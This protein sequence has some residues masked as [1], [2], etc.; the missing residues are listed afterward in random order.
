V[1][2]GYLCG[3]VMVCKAKLLYS[4]SDGTD[5]SCDVIVVGLVKFCLLIYLFILLFY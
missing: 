5:Y 1:E 3:V 2:D 4:Y